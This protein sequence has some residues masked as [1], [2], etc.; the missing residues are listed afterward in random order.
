MQV[1]SAVFSFMLSSLWEWLASV[2][3]HIIVHILWFHAGAFSSLMIVFIV[4]VG[5]QYHTGSDSANFLAWEVD[6]T[7]CQE[8]IQREINKVLYCTCMQPPYPN[9]EEYYIPS[10][11][12]VWKPV[13]N[14]GTL[15]LVHSLLA[16]CCGRSV[17]L[18]FLFLFVNDPY[19]CLV[20]W[21]LFFCE[22]FYFFIFWNL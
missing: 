11:L 1:P 19:N 17:E 6:D 4:G 16:V 2:A 8:K 14:Q 20:L 21:I 3:D 7:F 22:V 13:S 18:R 9:N 5:S 10:I 12:C 15:C